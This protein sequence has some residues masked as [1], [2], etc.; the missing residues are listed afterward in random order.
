MEELKRY[1]IIRKI[2]E[3]GTSIAYMAKDLRTGKKVTLKVLK[4]DKQRSQKARKNMENEAAVLKSLKHPRIQKLIEHRDDH[5]VTEYISGSSLAEKLKRNGVYS[6]KE[7]VGIA[8]ELIG[9][10]KYLHGLKEP[11]IY[12]DLKPANI[13][14][15]KDG[16]V[17]LID[18]GAARFYRK[19]EKS[20]TSYLGTVGFAAPEQYGTLGQTDPKTD[21]YCFGMTLLQMTT[22]IDIKDEAA[23]ENFKLNGFPTL[24]E[25]FTK[26]INKCIKP[27]RDDRFRSCAEI[28]KALSESIVKRKRSGITR[29]IRLG[30]AAAILAAVLSGTILY[31]KPVIN[32]ISCDAE[33]RMPAFRGRLYVAKERITEFIN[34]EILKE[35][36]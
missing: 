29:Y 7:A 4:A 3:G 9:I 16:K 24:S 32:Y 23:L 6:E 26:I 33:T 8:L 36:R 18:F 35:E 31:S 15:G 22:G 11:V 34:K 1:R 17:S 25:A 14:I 2:G 13:I 21:I 10:L 20:D 30:V 27:G 28:E 19:G 12:R 5:M